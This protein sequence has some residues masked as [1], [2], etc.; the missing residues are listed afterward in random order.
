MNGLFQRGADEQTPG[1][2][3]TVEATSSKNKN[4][5]QRVEDEA[6]V[7]HMENILKV[8]L[9]QPTT[10]RVREEKTIIETLRNQVRLAIPLL[11]KVS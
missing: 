5:K 4:K 2:E 1:L 8:I 11:D 9:G 6:A 7:N 10:L 3:A